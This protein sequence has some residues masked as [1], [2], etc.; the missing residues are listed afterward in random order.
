MTIRALTDEI[1]TLT[2]R[3]NR[4]AADIRGQQRLLEQIRG[5]VAVA[6]RDRADR[7]NDRL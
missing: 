5:R 6:Q 7:S 4:L 1:E 2:Q 3:R